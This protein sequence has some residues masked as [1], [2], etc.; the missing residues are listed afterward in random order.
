MEAYYPL[1]K[2][3]YNRQYNFEYEYQSRFNSVLS[4]HL[5]FSING[6]PSFFIHS[7]QINDLVYEILKINGDIQWSSARLDKER[8]LN[9]LLK[10]CLIKEIEKSNEL[11]QV[12]SSKKE[13]SALTKKQAGRPCREKVSWTNQAIFSINGRKTDV[14]GR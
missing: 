1:H 10:T 11:E 3:Y 12:Y 5:P 14:S 9:T 6:Y 13:L 2:C 4:F 7:E 8:A